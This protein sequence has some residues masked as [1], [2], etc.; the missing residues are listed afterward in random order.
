[1]PSTG[2][3]TYLLAQSVLLLLFALLFMALHR[4]LLTRNGYQRWLE[5]RGDQ[6]VSGSSY[7]RW[8][9][10]STPSPRLGCSALFDGRS[11]HC[12]PVP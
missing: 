9:P 8:Q 5:N 10:S 11:G 4:T 6:A 12:F 1:M 7:S 2:M 3:S